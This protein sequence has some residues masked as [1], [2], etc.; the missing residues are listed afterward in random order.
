LDMTGK[1][2]KRGWRPGNVDMNT[3]NIEKDIKK[4]GQVDGENKR[5]F[6]W[7]RG[8]ESPQQIANGA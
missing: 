1:S 7:S 5:E 8:T 2:R 3:G 4:K 6:F